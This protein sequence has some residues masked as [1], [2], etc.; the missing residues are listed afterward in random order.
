MKK[1]FPIALSFLVSGVSFSNPRPIVD[2]DIEHIEVPGT[3]IPNDYGPG[4][5]GPMVGGS[6][7]VGAS[8][9]KKA[10]NRSSQKKV[11]DKVQGENKRVKDWFLAVINRGAN[12]FD[13]VLEFDFTYSRVDKF[14]Q[15]SDG[16]I[17]IEDSTC[18]NIGFGSDKQ[19]NCG[20]YQLIPTDPQKTQFEFSFVPYYFNSE[21]ELRFQWSDAVVFRGTPNEIRYQLD[22]ASTY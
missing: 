4:S 21:G 1:V 5:A 9:S 10:I 15:G 2:D 3:R 6:A 8:K 19:T 16:S 17:S 14:S 12:W 7:G 11:K 13:K 18:I 22:I 20:Q